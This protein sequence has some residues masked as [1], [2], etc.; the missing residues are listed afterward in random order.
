M[1]F[2]PTVQSKLSS[3]YQEVIIFGVLAVT[4]IPFFAVFLHFHLSQIFDL[5]INE[6]TL[7]HFLVLEGC[8]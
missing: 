7:M 5:Q 2:D 4:L 6:Y 3:L 8:H 1:A